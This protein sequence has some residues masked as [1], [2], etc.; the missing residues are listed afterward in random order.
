MISKACVQG[1]YQR[2]LEEIARRGVDLAVVVPPAWRDERGWLRLERTY[3]AGYRLLV[4]PMRLNGSFHLHYYPRLPRIVAEVQPDI[5]HVDEE[6][7]NLATKLAVRLARR[8]GAR[9]LF[10]TWQN[11]ARTYPPPFCWWERYAYRHAAYA[12]AGNHDALSV[13]RTKGYAGPVCVIPQFG[14][15]PALYGTAAPPTETFV[16]GYIGRLVPEKG[17]DDL[18]HAMSGVEGKWAIR[19]L[20]TGP[21]VERLRKLARAL[22]IADRVVFDGWIP[23]PRVPAF[24]GALHALVLPSHTVRN[25][26]EQFGRVLTEAMASGVPVVGSDSGEIPNVIGDA[27]LV[28]AEGD[29]EALR[30]HL[31]AL[32]EDDVLWADLARRGRNRV[33][34]RY[35]QAQVAADTVA[36]YR[37]MLACPPGS[38]AVE[39]QTTAISD[40]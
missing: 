30:A 7:Y 32:M 34:A 28:Y 2:K 37:E 29:V 10:F 36:V 33:L 11:R 5:L 26:Q 6:P 15:D 14:I 12:I 8:A 35:T 20:G 22:H 39:P 27:G 25:W 4:T 24:L 9:A 21:D 13:L 23:S 16:L 3:M 31:R 19:L 1:I 38:A 18:L 40:P 17:I